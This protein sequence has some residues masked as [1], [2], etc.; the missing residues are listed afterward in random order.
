MTTLAGWVSLG[1]V[2][3]FAVLAV[4]L[5]D[6]LKSIL[7]LTIASVSLAVYF[8]LLGAPYAAVFE[9]IVAAGLIT[10]LFLFTVSLADTRAVERLEDRKATLVG[11]FALAFV[12]IV[13][14]LWVSYVGALGVAPQSNFGDIGDALWIGRSVD[15]LAVTILIFIGVIGATRLTTAGIEALEAPAGEESDIWGETPA[16]RDAGGLAGTGSED[17]TQEEVA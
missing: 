11:V 8:Y 9:A 5:S 3:V 1:G 16:E 17:D 10:V 13:A 2:V 7:S 6:M 4:I 14:F 12:A 15:V